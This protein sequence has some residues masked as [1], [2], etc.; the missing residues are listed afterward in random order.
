MALTAIDL[1]TSPTHLQKARV[2]FDAKRGPN[3]VYSTELADGKPA[4]D[5]RK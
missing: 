4:L 2:E 5:Y 1:F 3:F